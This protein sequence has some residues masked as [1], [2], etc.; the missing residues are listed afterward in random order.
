MDYFIRKGSDYSELALELI[1]DGHTNYEDFIL[2]IQDATLTFSM[3]NSDTGMLKIHKAEAKVI[4]DEARMNC[5]LV[6]AFEPKDVRVPGTY[7][8][9]F[10]IT[11]N[12][13]N[14]NLIVPIREE[15]KI[16]IIK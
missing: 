2:Q 4:I 3:A 12:K 13:D 7:I 9:R 10:N 6:Y 11:F 5:Q 16:H 8:G 1:Q 15:L 14:S